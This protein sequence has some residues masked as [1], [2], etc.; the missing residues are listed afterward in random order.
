MDAE[1]WL[2][3]WRLGDIG[4][5]Q[6]DGH[7]LLKTHWPALGVEA[8]A[9]VFVPLAGKSLDMQWLAAQGHRVIGV[10]L[11]ALAVDEFFAAAAVAPAIEQRARHIVKSAGPTTFYCGDIFDLEPRDLAGA[12][13]A[14]DRAALIALPAKMRVRYAQH[15]ARLLPKDSI[16]LLIAIDYPVGAI[17]G[18]PF[19]VP[20]AEI[21]QLFADQFNIEILE[22]RD[23]LPFSANLK[24]RGV[25][26]LDET[27]YRMRRRA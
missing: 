10:E 16:T 9:T 1:F 24:A 20:E 4:F 6:P 23:G 18:P 21:A 25:A 13:A 19:A 12:A 7:D 14:Y 11:S 2:N 15:M 8:G 3:R 26:R 5:H 27:V 17:E 22:T